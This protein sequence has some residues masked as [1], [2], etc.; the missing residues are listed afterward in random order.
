MFW[1]FYR[2]VDLTGIQ[3]A[4]EEQNILLTQISNSMANHWA[5]W[6]S[7]AASVIIGLI[8]LWIARQQSKIM[9]KQHN[10]ELFNKRWVMLEEFKIL[11]DT[12]SSLQYANPIEIA[13][14]PSKN[15]YLFDDKLIEFSQKAY[16]VFGKKTSEKFTYV[17]NLCVEKHKRQNELWNIQQKLSIWDECVQDR[18]G[19]KESLKAKE[20]AIMNEITTL[21]TQVLL[22]WGPIYNLILNIIQNG[23]V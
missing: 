7:L 17:R 13:E 11:A 12:Y 3:T 22:S 21:S 19:S 2:N 20:Q 18:L 4:L 10:L 1:W 23:D 9:R 16:V 5:D 6:A 15:Y 8:T 14:D